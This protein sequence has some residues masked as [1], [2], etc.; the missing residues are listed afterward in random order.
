MERI[1]VGDRL[2]VA[3]GENKR[4]S[5][6]LIHQ[7]VIVKTVDTSD[8]FA[9]KLFALDAVD[10]GAKK[11]ELSKALNI[12]R[13]TINNYVKIR[14][15]VGVEG[16][17]PGYAP[18]R[19]KALKQ[20]REDVAHKRRQG[21]AIHQVAEIRKEKQQKQLPLPLE[22]PTVAENEQPYHQ[23]HEWIFTRYAGV[24]V[25]I[26]T[27]IKQHDWIRLIQSYVGSKFQVFQ[28]FLLMAALNI[29]SIEQLK[30][31]RLKEAARV[32]GLAELPSRKKTRQ[33]LYETAEYDIARQ[34]LD[35]FFQRQIEVGIVGLWLWFTDG[36]L[37]PYTGREK[38]RPAYNTQRRLMV[39]GR[40]CMVTTDQT[41]RIVDFEIQEGKGDLKE[42]IQALDH[43]WRQKLPQNVIHVFDREGDGA[44]FFHRLIQDNI[45]FV[46]W[47]KN[48]DT[49]KLQSLQDK[50]FT[51]TF[52]LNQKKYRVCE[53]TKRFT[54][55]QGEEK[56]SFTLRRISIWN[57]TS[58]HRTS[59]LSNVHAHTM[60]TQ[61][62]ALAIL[63][64]W[65]ASENTFKHIQERQP[66]HYQPGFSLVESEKQDIANPELKKKQTVMKSLK[67]E[68][69]NLYKKLSKSKEAK[70]KDGSPRKN[71][72]H[73]RLQSE[74]AQMENELSQVQQKTKDL[75]ERIDVTGLED[76]RNFK[77]LNNESKYLFDCA[78]SLVWNARKQMAEWLQE[79]Y[80]NKND[81]VDL[82]Y[83]ITRCHGWI[84]SDPEKVTVRLEPL[85]QPSRRTAQEQLCRKLASLKARTPT[86]KLLCIEVGSSPV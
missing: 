80:C 25:Y 1:S 5:I 23:E 57:V 72:A 3:Y 8:K 69:N 56:I 83:A 71:N 15:H 47:E 21:N 53:G 55:T 85:E 74:I 2:A 48:A 60:S 35:V 50:D 66:F 19:G 36:H 54:L 68:L 38:L 78:T 7:N 73:S 65:G 75:P 39:P 86:G 26:I 22:E 81:Y 59:G 49:K 34:L 33:W 29:R 82:F 46:T 42:H 32:L 70:N 17:I 31:I 44:P 63:N 37:L 76:Y 13:Q 52:E 51:E 79:M 11:T 41:G 67:K 10:L 64:R 45:S 84:Q 20:Y 9:I 4:Q 27:L 28:V 18:S 14:E 6:A 12:T 58:N 43:K 77:Q 40:T 61:E 24:F 30:N 62:C 16:L